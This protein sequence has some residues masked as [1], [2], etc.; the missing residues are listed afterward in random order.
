MAFARSASPCSGV[1]GVSGMLHAGDAA[2]PET[3]CVNLQPFHFF[4]MQSCWFQVVLVVLGL[5][6]QGGN[7]CEGFSVVCGSF[8]SI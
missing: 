8:P 6:P 4:P 1:V 7:A 3:V 2:E 5:N